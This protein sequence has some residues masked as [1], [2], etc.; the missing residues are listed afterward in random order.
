MELRDEARNHI[1]HCIGNGQKTN[2]WHDIWCKEGPISKIIARRQICSAGF[3][4]NASV[5]S[6][7]ENGILTFP[8]EWYSQ[9]AALLP[10]KQLEL[11]NGKEDMVKWRS[12]KGNL[13]KN[14]NSEKT[15]T[16]TEITRFFSVRFLSVFL[17]FARSGPNRPETKIRKEL[18]PSLFGSVLSGRF[19]FAHP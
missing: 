5:A 8:E 1:W 17:V 2:V 13:V 16:E 12:N 10:N 9:H 19:G 3:S 15:Q 11:I 18:E 6:V 14:R 4:N 7:V